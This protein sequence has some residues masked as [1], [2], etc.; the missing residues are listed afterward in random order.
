MRYHIIDDE[1]NICKVLEKF[2][3]E[4][5]D[6]SFVEISLNG[7]EAIRKIKK[8]AY[9]ISLVDLELGDYY[10][11]EIIDYIK[12]YQ[13]KCICIIITGYPSFD[14]AKLALEKG[15]FGYITKPIN[16]DELS[17]ILKNAKRLKELEEKIRTFVTIN[18]ER[19]NDVL[20]DKEFFLKRYSEE[21]KNSLK[22]KYSF[23][24]L[25]I[26][27]KNLEK[28]NSLKKREFINKVAM[29]LYDS[30]QMLDI[31]TFIEDSFYIL[32][33]FTEKENIS[34][35]VSKLR[36][37]LEIQ[38]FNK[39]TPVK[40]LY[41]YI[42]FEYNNPADIFY[43]LQKEMSEINENKIM[44]QVVYGK[45]SDSKEKINYSTGLRTYKQNIDFYNIIK[46]KNL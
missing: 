4:N 5:F 37:R 15:V 2:I 1:I 19:K 33:S 17:L 23:A 32:F 41:R 9:D 16:F 36:E 29:L 35:V 13:P 28:L 31:M 27:L 42:I 11:T 3:S 6:P 8:N 26:K 44:D 40:Y 7:A 18:S 30:L 43:L 24:I 14:S 22:K 38:E 25:G 45:I 46:R 10:G 34:S 21:F 20:T 39:N 12:E